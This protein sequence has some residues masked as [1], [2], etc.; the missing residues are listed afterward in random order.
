MKFRSQVGQDR[1]VCEFFNYKRGG[2]FLDIGAFDGKE[3]SNTYYLEKELGWNGI[4]VEAGQNNYSKLIQNRN[5]YV[6][7]KAI[8]GSNGLVKF[9]EN[10]TVGKIDHKGEFIEAITFDKL[11]K[12]YLPWGFKRRIGEIDYIS[13]DI[14]GGEYDALT[15]FPFKTHQVT[16]WTIEHNAHE[17]SG[18]MKQKIR[19]LMYKNGY[20]L[21]MVKPPEAQFEDWFISAAYI[22]RIEAC[23]M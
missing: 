7:N 15:K 14:E 1:W 3:I 11:L 19:D 18:I 21:V 13:L 2:Y 22:S 10:W 20:H 8:Y 12:L 4:C 9:N 17:D 5:C 16:L 6:L 23:G